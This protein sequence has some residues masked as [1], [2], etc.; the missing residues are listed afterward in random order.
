MLRLLLAALLALVG[1]AA[2]QPAVGQPLT[3]DNIYSVD[4][5]VGE[6]VLAPGVA[7]GDHD[8]TQVVQLREPSALDCAK[9]CR[10]ITSCDWWDYTACYSDQ[11]RSPAGALAGGARLA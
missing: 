9:A 2:A 10:N 5:G 11:V 4:D 7:W 1:R 3:P 6:T 8:L